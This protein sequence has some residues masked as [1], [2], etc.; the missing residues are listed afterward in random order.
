MQAQNWKVQFRCFCVFYKLT[1]KCQK[2]T[3]GRT[4]VAICRQEMSSEDLTMCDTSKKKK[5]K[6]KRRAGSKKMLLILA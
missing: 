3:M 2:K 1:L 5:K 6:K 4:R